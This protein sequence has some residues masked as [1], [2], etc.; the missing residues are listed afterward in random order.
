MR[1]VVRVRPFLGGEA[2]ACTAGAAG[3]KA[4]TGVSVVKE[5]SEI[6]LRSNP[7]SREAARFK[8]DACY[9]QDSTQEQLF[10]EVEDVVDSVL[11]GINTTLFA[12]GMTGAGKTHTMQGNA[13][14][15]G[16]IPRVV[17]K[18]ASKAAETTETGQSITIATSY[19]EIYNERVFDLLTPPPTDDAPSVDLA[20]RQNSAGEITV[21]GLVSKE[22]KDFAEFEKVYQTGCR[23]RTTASTS[24]NNASSRSHAILSLT[25]TVRKESS[26]VKAKLHLIDLA[27]SEDNRHTNNHGLRMTE[28]SSINSSLFVLGKVVGALNDGAARVPYRD[29]KL[30]RLLQDSLGGKSNAVL[31]A[32]IA[33]GVSYFAETTRTLNFASK[34][35]RIVNKPVVHET[36]APS[37]AEAA[38]NRKRKL[39]EWKRA[40][41]KLTGLSAP[42]RVSK[43]ERSSGEPTHKKRKYSSAVAKEG[44]QERQRPTSSRPGHSSKY[45][46]S[47]VHS[48]E[49]RQKKGHIDAASELF[50]EAEVQRRLQQEREALQREQE[51]ARRR[52]SRLSGENDEDTDWVPPDEEMEEV[53]EEYHEE[54]CTPVR[55]SRKEKSLD[56]DAEN[57][58]PP[59]SQIDLLRALTPNTKV[60]TAKEFLAKAKEQEAKGQESNAIALYTH[61]YKLLPN[62]NPKL[63]ERIAAL[64][65]KVAEQAQ[66]GDSSME[67]DSETRTPAEQLADQ[68]LQVL[69][70]GTK[71]ELCQLHMIGEKRAAL[72][73]KYRSFNP[74]FSSLDDFKD[75]MFTEKQFE[76]FYKKNVLSA[77]PWAT[78]SL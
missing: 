24:L 5:K 46:A 17:Q 21:Q 55:S 22:I 13:Q 48:Q 50:I 57:K 40:K 2:G 33:P 73:M 52:S 3:A 16:I 37:A 6:E 10:G 44:G 53:E 42:S 41:G 39:E 11:K 49:N 75:S 45:H 28:S 78:G 67:V 9:D 8:F 4:H 34:S 77:I 14:A 38:A 20:I 18:L 70:M 63:L 25:V 69:N 19:L 74:P 54:P 47:A 31:I 71:K 7:T 29:S 15:P 23:N 56:A 30:T 62:K 1:V 66:N 61:A 43:P 58:T 68:I 12:Y 36:A 32:N 64:E 76:G 60:S 65:A 35:R 59:R 26:V 27:G 51:E 72:I